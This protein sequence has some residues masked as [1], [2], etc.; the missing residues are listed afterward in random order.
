MKV[1]IIDDIPDTVKDI[2]DYCEEQHWEKKL[3]GFGDA[4]KYLLEFDPDIIILDWKDDADKIDVGNNI[5]DH[6]WN[7]CFRPIIIFSANAAVIDI[8]DKMKESSFLKVISKGDEQPVIDFLRDTQK[9]VSALATYRKDMGKAVI[10]SLNS[11]DLMKSEDDIE[12]NA[13]GYVL[14][15]RTSAFFDKEFTGE[16]SPSWVQ[17]LCPPVSESLCVCDIIRIK[18][19][20]AHFNSVGSPEEYFLILTP[21]CDMVGEGERE[22]KVSHVLCARCFPKEK[23]HECAL[24]KEPSKGNIKSTVSKLN[25]GYCKSFVAVPGFADMI[26]YMTVDLKKL[27]LIELPKIAVSLGSIKETDEYVRIASIASPYREQIVWAY[28]QN[29]CRPGVPDRNTEMW[30]KEI[31]TK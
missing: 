1:L 23:F 17:Y 12:D 3:V 25:L 2:L 31:L 27:E 16:L 19:Q 26:P 9:F 10:S 8:S 11:V 14:S 4:Y 18:S 7:I 30:A 22:P 29:A 6:I 20:E 5:L 15:K 13:V 24:S 28:M 21:S